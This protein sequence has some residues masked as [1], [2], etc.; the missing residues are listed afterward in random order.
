M[1]WPSPLPCSHR[2]PP[3]DPRTR[4]PHEDAL[5]PGGLFNI[6]FTSRWF[7]LYQPALSTAGMSARIGWGDKECETNAK[8][9]PATDYVREV[10]QHPFDDAYWKL[11]ATESYVDRVNVPTIVGMGWQDFQTQ[12]TSGITL[13]H[14]LK[15]PKRL[16]VLPGGHGVVLGQKVFQDDQVRWFDRWLKGAEGGVEKEG[17]V[18]PDRR[19]AARHGQAV[20]CRTDRPSDLHLSHGDGAHRE[21]R[22]VLAPR[23]AGRGAGLP[24]RADERGPDDARR[25]VRNQKALGAT[26][27][28]EHTL[29]SRSRRSSVRAARCGWVPT[30]SSRDS[31]PIGSYGRWRVPA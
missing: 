31:A 1:R 23:G 19:R 12:V 20:L 4:N 22:A 17:V 29:P 10:S 11:R 2:G 18:L 30:G 28:M 9:H 25:I 3:P 13:F 7:T 15:V 24:Q 8:A 21:Q 16:Y 26:S 27:I 5:Y 14:H 6:G